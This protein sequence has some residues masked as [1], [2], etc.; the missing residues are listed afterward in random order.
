MDLTQEGSGSGW[1]ADC[2]NENGSNYWDYSDYWAEMSSAFSHSELVAVT[3]LCVPLLVLGLMGNILTILVVWLRP[4]MRSTTYLYLSSMAVSDILMLVLMPLDLY[5]LWW[6]RPW[7]L[8]DAVCKLSQFV[9]ECCTFSSILHMTALGAERYVGVCFPL[10]A[11]LLVTR[12]RVRVLIG[13]L[14]GVSVLSAGPVLVLVG[15]EP[16]EG[17]LTE[18]RVTQWAESSGLMVAMLWL[19]NLYF[20]IPLM[21]LTMLYTLIARRLRQRRHVHRDQTH[22]QTLRMMVVIVCVFVVCWLPFHVART[23]FC[24]SL[25][26]SV[27]VYF[28]SQYL[29]L[30]SFV[31]F[32]C[33]A[34]INPLLYNI[35]SSRY[36]D[37]VR[38]LL[39]PRT[40]PLPA[41]S[42]SSTHF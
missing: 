29:N 9:S 36:R 34:A 15:A 8:G 23:L 1:C 14:W 24:L 2:Q 40:R 3:T 6:Y 25:T 35:M 19:S 32:Y 31:L 17:N 10:R 11:R 4:Q 33:S 7:F 39:R 30:V 21:T 5:K 13:A 28:L 27:Q 16:V 42:P 12:G 18:C 41:P 26:S 37:N 38:A 22:R 20:I